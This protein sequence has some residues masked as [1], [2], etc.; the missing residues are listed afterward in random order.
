MCLVAHFVCWNHQTIVGSRSV[1]ASHP[2]V[3]RATK[4][5]AI[6]GRKVRFVLL[7]LR[8]D[9]RI[10]LRERKAMAEVKAVG[11]WSIVARWERMNETYRLYS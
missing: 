9:G 11:G 3:D 1:S 10:P 4:R 7:V 5:L 6:G 8:R 2:T